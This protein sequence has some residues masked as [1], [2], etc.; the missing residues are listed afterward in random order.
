[1]EQLAAVKRQHHLDPLTEWYVLAWDAFRAPRFPADEALR[2]SRVV[3]LDFDRDVKNRICEIKSGD[4]ILWD[5]RTRKAKGKLGPVGEEVM[6]DT[7]HQAAVTAREQ[8]T[9]AA[10]ELIERAGLSGDA[11]LLTA[12]EALLNVLPPVSTVPG[13]K[14]PDEHLAAANNDFEALEKLRRLAFAEEVPAPKEIQRTL[15]GVEV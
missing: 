4:V 1:M 5:S 14:K 15:P 12:L 11:T 8:N 6:L 7:L 3:G 9:G 10:A 13:K 2:L